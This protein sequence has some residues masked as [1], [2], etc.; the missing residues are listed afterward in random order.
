M[1]IYK[2][3]IIKELN[4]KGGWTGYSLQ[5]TKNENGKVIFGS[6]Q[7]QSIQHG[8][9][10]G[11]TENMEKLCKMLG[12]KQISDF[13]EYIPDDRYK[14]LYESGYFDNCGYPVPEPKE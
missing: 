12:D 14:A 13:V 10:I 2:C 9:V 3:D 8:K 11:I 4:K 1:F 5:K 7:V 6:S